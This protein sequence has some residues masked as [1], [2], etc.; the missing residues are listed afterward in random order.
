MERLSVIAKTDVA[1]EV[2]DD[3]GINAFVTCIQSPSVA[4]VV[5]VKYKNDKLYYRAYRLAIPK[6]LWPIWLNRDFTPDL[7]FILS[8]RDDDG[9]LLPKLLRKDDFFLTVTPTSIISESSEIDFF[10]QERDKGQK[11][12]FTSFDNDTFNLFIHPQ[13]GKVIAYNFELEPTWVKLQDPNLYSFIRG[14]IYDAFEIE[15][16]PVDLIHQF[17]VD[18]PADEDA[19]RQN[20]FVCFMNFLFNK[21]K[22]ESKIVL[23]EEI[24]D[25]LCWGKKFDVSFSIFTSAAL[26][27]AIIEIQF[28]TRKQFFEDVALIVS[29]QI[30]RELTALE[31]EQLFCFWWCVHYKQNVLHKEEI[32]LY[33]SMYKR[34]RCLELTLHELCTSFVFFLEEEEDLEEE[35]LKNE[36]DDDDKTFLEH[37]ASFYGIYDAMFVEF[38]YDVCICFQDKSYESCIKRI[39][40]TAKVKRYLSIF[41][42]C[43]L[44]K[45]EK[46][47]EE[48]NNAISKLCAV[49]ENVTL[50]ERRDK[51]FKTPFT[52]VLFRRYVSK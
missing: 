6:D 46:E 2:E 13:R 5:F 40:E 44:P 25:V 23:T 9:D 43:S 1:V 10:F 19:E 49:M 37:L 29:S 22:S 11:F 41:D 38:L 27:F 51:I 12:N 39:F 48:T 7:S 18:S 8:A 30:N 21:I 50:E 28:S 52:V 26:Y 24:G 17:L 33:K 34:Q 32:E 20:L 15:N 16:K 4:G 36:K 42:R 3:D 47:E 35:D 45:E 31:R 14:L